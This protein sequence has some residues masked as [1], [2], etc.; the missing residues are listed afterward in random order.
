MRPG[1]LLIACCLAGAAVPDDPVGRILARVSEEAEVFRQMAPRLITQ[2]T[3]AQRTLKAPP[4]FRPR[5]GQ[6]ALQPPKPEYRTREI[7]SEYAFSNFKDSPGVLREFRQIETIDGRRLVTQA[8]ARETLAAG[9]RTED[10]RSKRR[11]I[12]TFEKHGLTGAAA[13]FGQVLLLFTRSRLSD[14]SFSVHGQGRIG[15]EQATILSFA[16]HAGS[17]SL[18]IFQTR[19]A[20]HVPLAGE[21][22]VRQPDGLPLRVVLRAARNEGFEEVRD[23]ASVDYVMTPHGVL[24]PVAVV[25]REFSGDLMRA[26]NVFRYAPF[27]LFA[28]D[29]DIRFAEDPVK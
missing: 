26:E 14:Y 15:A 10:D 2:E 9:M 3:L 27:R 8:K 16:Q 13:D 6:A 17:G 19:K 4:R 12:E 1:T 21:L 7:V 5:I 18:V 20:L 28:A 23:E 11:M 29:A 24:A 25:H 22:W